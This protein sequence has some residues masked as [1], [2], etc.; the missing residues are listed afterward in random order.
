MSRICGIVNPSP[1]ADRSLSALK[2]LIQPQIHSDDFSVETSSADGAAFG[3]I[4][5]KNFNFSTHLHHQDRELL[6]A[7]S[8]Y[9]R[10]LPALCR[11]A[12]QDSNG[13]FH[14]TTPAEVIAYLL[15]KLGTS[16]LAGVSGCYA[17]ALWLAE[18]RTLLLGSDRFGMIPFYYRHRGAQLAFASEIKALVNLEPDESVNL[19]VLQEIVALGHPLADGTLYPSVHRLPPASIL[20]FQNGRVEIKRYW[21]YDQL[22]RPPKVTVPEFLETAQTLFGRSISSLLTQI[23][24]PVCMLSS[25]YDSRRILLELAR[26][27][28]PV[29]TY[30]API[31]LPD[32]GFTC[33]VPIARALCKRLGV[34][35]YAS[36]FPDPAQSG[37]HARFTH[38]FLDFQTDFHA[39][40]L[41]LIRELPAAS[42]VN[43]D[44]LGG[45]TLF[46]S[47]FIYEAEAA[48]ADDPR[49]L[50]E[51]VV[52]RFPD[53]WSSHF[54]MNINAPPLI[55]R[56]ERIL[57]ELP[58]IDHR[59]TLF[60]FTNWSRRMT[61]LL[62][63]GLLSLKIDSVLPFLDYDLVDF[64]FSLPPL[65]KRIA[66]VSKVMLERS[67]P[68]LACSIPTSH[69]PGIYTN[70]DEFC[71]PF[72]ESVPPGYRRRSQTSLYRASASDVLKGR[73]LMTRLSTNSQAAV[74]GISLT[75]SMRTVPSFL[76]NRAWPLTFVGQYALQRRTVCDP[77]W[78]ATHL[79][80]A[81]AY[82]YAR[83]SR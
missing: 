20:T 64:L 19:P 24:K 61:V 69:Y 15:P 21:W 47:N 76:L 43:F 17:F 55:D 38:R 82:M 62:T 2:L 34:S 12:A 36:D 29:A 71:K 50:A 7:F 5:F 56:I 45:D 9:F 18:S 27:N 26:C 35:H 65:A 41:P 14:A 13:D 11:K 52:T 74:L 6:C 60:Y 66:E 73:S 59:H 63:Y 72:C 83:E 30:T 44:G 33:D 22:P 8:G 25:G 75:R 67:D 31:V 28:K 16:W 46:E 53:L 57:R 37:S 3:R 81:R 23:E 70:P 78:A 1:S 51:S 48:H 4:F 10:D 79:E 32:G 49:F 58:E 42:G 68:D 80:Q 39:W 54:R 40:I 77:V